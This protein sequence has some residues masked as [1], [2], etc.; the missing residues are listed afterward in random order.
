M[1][2]WRVPRL[3]HDSSVLRGHHGDQRVD[4]VAFRGIVRDP[5]G[6]GQAAG[7]APVDNCKALAAALLNAFGPHEPVAGR[8]PISGL[9]VDMLRPQA[10]R[11]MVAIAA[12]AQRRNL[13]S[14]V[15]AGEALVL[16]GSGDRS[17]SE[18]KKGFFNRSA[19]FRL[20]LAA[21][22]RAAPRLE[23]ARDRFTAASPSSGFGDYFRFRLHRG[24][25]SRRIRTTT[26]FGS[27][28]RPLPPGPPQRSAVGVVPP[29]LA[30]A[31]SPDIRAV[32]R[33]PHV[34]GA[35]HLLAPFAAGLDSR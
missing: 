32:R 23:R 29:A 21:L 8:R 3:A 9:D 35:Y 7:D 19:G 2:G 10:C 14:A 30:S 20:V 5:V 25:L 22:R 27:L 31:S 24:I 1:S 18:L 33:P 28:S 34:L 17:A 12:I 4:V 11:A 6:P 16:G 26:G 15:L 13:R